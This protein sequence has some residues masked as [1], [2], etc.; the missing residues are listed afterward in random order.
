MSD[1]DDPSRQ[2][3]SDDETH[4]LDLNGTEETQQLPDDSWLS[5]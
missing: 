4:R 3:G 2:T 1:T 5:R